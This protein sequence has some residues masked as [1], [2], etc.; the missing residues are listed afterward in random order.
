MRLYHGS[1]QI[2]EVPLSGIGRKD[3]DFG[4]GFYVTAIQEQAAQWAVRMKLLRAA[5]TAWI[6]AYD[7]NIEAAIADGFR[8]LR[9]EA[10]DDKWLDFIVSSRQGL[11]PWKGYDLIEG[12]VADDK[13]IDTVE[14]YIEGIIT[15]EQALGQLVYAKPNH[16]LCLLNQVLIDKHLK[17]CESI[18]VEG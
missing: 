12:G 2:I 4:P 8:L 15:A 3:L 5:D 1:T 9:L 10:Y 14:N 16:Q 13:V 17:F 7:F 18:S 11:Q 6:N